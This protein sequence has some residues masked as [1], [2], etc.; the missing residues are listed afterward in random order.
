MTKKELIEK[1]K[2]YP[3]DWEVKIYDES[4]IVDIKKISPEKYNDREII[5]IEIE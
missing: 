3:G 2:D 5:L 1:L 4:Y